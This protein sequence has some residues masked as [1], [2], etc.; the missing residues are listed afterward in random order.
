MITKIDQETQ[1]QLAC[2]SKRQWD[3]K[4]NSFLKGAQE[5]KKLKQIFET[6]GIK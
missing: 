5:I 6:I 1:M 3:S 4:K 2:F